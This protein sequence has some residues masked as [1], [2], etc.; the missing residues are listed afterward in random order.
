VGS[1]GA[2]ARCRDISIAGSVAY[3]ADEDAGLQVVDVTNPATPSHIGSMDVPGYAGSVAVTTANV[4][5]AGSAGLVMVPS[6]CQA[7]TGTGPNPIGSLD[8]VLGPSHPNPL[9]SGASA[10]IPF[11]L[12]H[13]GDVSLRILDVSGRQVASLLHELLEAGEHRIPWDGRDDRSAPVPAGMYF[14]ELQ[15]GAFKATRA[16]VKLH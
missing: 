15:A 2:S 8:A 7:A 16:M 11:V 1:L 6:Q 13:R 4:Y 5:L 12:G 14:Y 9:F 10:I 3:I